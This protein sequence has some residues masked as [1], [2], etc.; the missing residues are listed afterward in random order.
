MDVGLGP[1]VVVRLA[2]AVVVGRLVV[3]GALD[4]EVTVVGGVRVEG[5]RPRDVVGEPGRVVVPGTVDVGLRVVVD[6]VV[7]AF[8]SRTSNEA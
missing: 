1:T 2:G 7:E 4:V 8:T 5:V 6:V 3:V